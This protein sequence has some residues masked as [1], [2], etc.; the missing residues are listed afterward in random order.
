M[1]AVKALCRLLL[2]STPAE[3]VIACT[4]LLCFIQFAWL[5]RDS[6]FSVD[7]GWRVVVARNLRP[8]S[9]ITSQIDYQGKVEDPAGAHV[10][11]FVLWFS[12]APGPGLRIHYAHVIF[13]TLISP[14][15]ALAGLPGAQLLS[16]LCGA[17]TGM[18]TAG[19]L[20]RLASPSIASL[21]VITVMLGIPSAL[22]SLM[23]WEHQL[24]LALCL[25]ALWCWIEYQTSRRPRPWFIVTSIVCLAAACV[26]RIELLFIIAP[27]ILWTCLPKP[28]TR[29]LLLGSGVILALA[30][31]YILFSINMPYYM[32]R[33]TLDSYPQ[34][35]PRALDALRSFFIGYGATDATWISL[36]VIAIA[37]AVALRL[38]RG[39]WWFGA[40]VVT[41]AG[42][43]SLL[44]VLNI[45][46][47]GVVN[48]GLLGVSPLLLIALIAP[49]PDVRVRF[50]QRGLWTIIAGF[51]PCLLVF[52]QLALRTTVVM[53]HLGATWANRYFLALYPLMAIIALVVVAAWV[54]GISDAP[55]R[56][57]LRFAI[58]LV[59][60]TGI[61][62]NLPGLYRINEQHA[63]GLQVCQPIWR[64]AQKTVITDKWWLAETCSA[65]DA[66]RDQVYFLSP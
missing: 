63:R 62:A 52:Q 20:K 58:A 9:L 53:A 14:L 26:L 32:P 38:R 48:P 24:S 21:G 11:Y 43:V 49:V 64:S 29:A 41:V 35:I 44:S 37:G 28:H 40:V 22:Y 30:G 27:V 51:V 15:L 12:L 60:V 23:V 25:M 46:P 6:F 31:I 8:D 16:I 2:T 17:V 55:S 45:R 65:N 13:A 5:P 33:L 4:V 57:I 1:R 10:P 42:L 19:I 7:E 59:V 39:A 18:C 66:R 50:L 54:R 36:A 56:V 34:R 47:F 61:V 3:W